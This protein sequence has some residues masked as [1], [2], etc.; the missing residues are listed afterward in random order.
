MQAAVEKFGSISDVPSSICAYLN[1]EPYFPKGCSNNLSDIHDKSIKYEQGLLSDE[2]CGMTGSCNIP[3]KTSFNG[4]K[5][6]IVDMGG[7]MEEVDAGYIV[8]EAGNYTFTYVLKGIDLLKSLDEETYTNTENYIRL[9]LKD[10]RQG[11]YYGIR[12]GNEENPVFSFSYP[13]PKDVNT[14]NEYNCDNFLNPLAVGTSSS[15]TTAYGLDYNV[16]LE[17]NYAPVF[18]GA[19]NGSS[20]LLYFHGCR[21]E[22]SGSNSSCS[23]RT[24]I[25][26]K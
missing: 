6:G 19:Y 1:V 15:G 10:R 7:L 26:P 25:V 14:V 9:D 5:C 21:H 23:A 17:K 22:W 3:E 20:G 16:M 8:A 13:D 18:G 2:N 24:M 12:V 4:Q 11:N